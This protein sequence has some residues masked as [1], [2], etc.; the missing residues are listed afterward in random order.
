[1]AIRPHGLWPS[2]CVGNES[3]LHVKHKSSLRAHDLPW[4]L[5]RFTVL[6]PHPF[7]I[8]SPPL[9]RPL[10]PSALAHIL[11]VSFPSVPTHLSLFPRTTSTDLPSFSLLRTC[12]ISIITITNASS[13]PSITPPTR[14]GV[15]PSPREDAVGLPEKL[16]EV[17][18]SSSEDE[19]MYHDQFP[20]Q[21]TTVH[22]VSYVDHHG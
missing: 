21:P 12:Q 5:G 17:E 8:P 6:L 13:L 4:P 14:R 19:E 18:V 2:V 22:I 1:M 7:I 15:M 9:H 16:H 3:L 11:S 20:P 10:S